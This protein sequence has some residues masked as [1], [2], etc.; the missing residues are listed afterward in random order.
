M[1]SCLRRTKGR[2]GTPPKPSNQYLTI[3][4]FK[5]MKG[6]SKPCR[7]SSYRHPH[8]DG[9]PVLI[10]LAVSIGHNSHTHSI[11]LANFSKTLIAGRAF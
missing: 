9:A 2:L 10:F 5:N 6:V 3:F 1:V 7:A 4:K 11:S 8:R